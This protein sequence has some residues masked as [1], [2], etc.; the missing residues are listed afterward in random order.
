MELSTK[1]GKFCRPKLKRTFCWGSLACCFGLGSCVFGVCARR[2]RVRVGPLAPPGQRGPD[3]ESR[4]PD[5]R[6]KVS[7][8]LKAAAAYTVAANGARRYQ[9]G[10]HG[11]RYQ[12]EARPKG[13]L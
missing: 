9:F 8:E 11:R 1:G 10:G 12:F 13:A 5:E 2:P 4:A 7:A 6:E 3:F